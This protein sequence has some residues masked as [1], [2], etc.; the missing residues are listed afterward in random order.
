MSLHY[1]NVAIIGHGVLGRAYRAYYQRLGCVVTVYDT[2]PLRSETPS[3]TTAVVDADLVVVAVGTPFKDG[4]LCMT[5]VEQVAWELATVVNHPTHPRTIV[6]RSTLLP[7]TVDKHFTLVRRAAEVLYIPEIRRERDFGQ[8]PHTV[9][10]G[11]KEPVQ[12]EAVK[13]ICGCDS[14]YVTDYRTAETFKL[15]CNAFHTLKAAFANE[16]ASITG[17]VGVDADEVLEMMRKIDPLASVDHYLAPGKPIGGACLPKDLRGLVA[18]AQAL[19][20][21]VPLLCGAVDEVE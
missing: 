10:V 15:V 12:A 16:V 18:F 9:V 6:V 7:G 14:L 17:A 2:N 20:V 11:A 19:G 13:E 4:S 21:S 1:K 8:P 5:A 3:V